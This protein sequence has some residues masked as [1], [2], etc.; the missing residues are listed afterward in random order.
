MSPQTFDY[1]VIGAGTAGCVLANRLSAD[2]AVSVLL[3]EAGGQ[4][5]HP[6]IHVPAGF[7]RLMDHKDITWRY[8]TAGSPHT[9]S[10]EIMFPRGR[11]LGGSSSINGLLYVRPFREDLDEWAARSDDSW[12]YDQVLPYYRKS[13]TWTGKPSPLR[14][15]EGPVRVTRTPEPPPICD[16]AVKAGQIAGLEYREDP[17]ES[18]THASIW[19]YQQTRDGRRRSS[20]ARGYLRPA[21]GR[22]NLTVLTRAQVSRL[23]ITDK[24]CQGVAVRRDNGAI[25]ECYARRE[26]ILSA[27]AIGSPQILQVSG[28]GPAEVLE[29]HG[30]RPAHLLKGVGNN[31]QDHYIV[32]LGY[33][34]K[35]TVTA[36]QRGRGLRLAGEVMNYLLRGKGLLTYS[37]SSVGAFYRSKYSQRTDVQYVM[38][39]GSFKHGRIGEL[40]ETPG[41]TIGCWQMR[42]KSRGH[43]RIRSAD[44]A[45]AP[46]IDPAYLAD[47]F[48]AAVIAEGLKFGRELF[49]HEPL[50]RYVVT[51]SIPGSRYAD[52]EALIRYARSNG[53]TV[54][55]PAGTCAMGA[56]DAAVVDAQLRVRGIDRLRVVDA[57]IMPNVTS[58]NTNATVLM[59]AEKAAAMILAGR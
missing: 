31:L 3:I 47:P 51:E 5:S 15:T 13:E 35:D 17:N 2:S 43:V 20:A 26:V 19:Y 12:R 7:I 4:D 25:E 33:A 52:D 14:G 58:T 23:L 27:G 44:I 41:V 39:G 37:A 30:I 48:D 28:V 54:F 16:A 42:P 57:S 22:T 6:M 24:V 59:I 40:E 21:R 50:A 45:V 1:I 9:G 8:R 55:H 29:E 10:R 38:A 56:G 36:N 49:S 34:V 53:S 11:V 46:E 32:R 18:H